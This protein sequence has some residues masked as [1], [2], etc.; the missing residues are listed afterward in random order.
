ME[1]GSLLVLIS[2]CPLLEQLKPLIQL[3]VKPTKENL[4][5][6]MKIKILSLYSLG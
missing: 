3:Y 6:F 1:Y 2:L 5:D 4:T